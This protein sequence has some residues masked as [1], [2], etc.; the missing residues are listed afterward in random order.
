MLEELS[1]EPVKR[2]MKAD[3]GGSDIEVYESITAFSKRYSVMDN[4]AVFCWIKLVDVE[5]GYGQDL[6]NN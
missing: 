4:G 3:P 5:S 6:S 1:Q 2:M